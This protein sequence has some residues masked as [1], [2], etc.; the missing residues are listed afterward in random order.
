M[1]AAAGHPVRPASTSTPQPPPWHAIDASEVA[2]RLESD[3]HD[4]LSSAEADERAALHG[5]NALE[6]EPERGVV[7]LLVSQF[8]SPLIVIL[9]VAGVVTVA[10]GKYVDAAVITVVL[11]VNASIGFVQE[12]RADRSMHALM[13]LSSPTAVVVRDGR[14]TRVDASRLVSGDVVLLESGA[15]VPADLR[16]TATTSLRVDESLLTGESLPVDKDP[17]SVAEAAAAADRRSIAHAGTTVASGRGRGFVV[18][19][20]TSTELGRIAERIRS[21]ERPV[22]PLQARMARFANV[23]TMA[24]LATVVVSFALGLWRGADPADMFLVAVALAVAVIPEGLPIAFTVALALGVRRMADRNALVRSL[25]AVE[26]LGSTDVIGSDKTGTLTANRMTVVEAWTSD[27]SIGLAPGGEARPG[28]SGTLYDPSN[29]L[30][31]SLRSAVLANEADL[32]HVDGRVEHRGDPTETALLEVAER[33][34]LRVEALRSAARIVAVRPFEP[35][36]QYAAVV[37]DEEGPVLRVKGAPERIVAGCTTIATVSGQAAIDREAVLAAAARMAERGLRVLAAAER[38]LPAALAGESMPEPEGLLFTGLIGMQ[39][40][41]RAGVE[42]AIAACQRA[43]V[44]VLMITGDHVATARAIAQ[45]LGI[46]GAG[47]GGAMTGADLEALDADGLGRA[48]REVSVFARV[49]PDQKLAIVR[50][51]QAQGAVVAVTGDGINDA[52][53]LKA[54]D[55]GIA[56]GASGTDVAREASDMVLTDDAFVSIAAAVEEGRVVFENVRKVVS[57]LLATGVATI[58]SILGSLLAGW[59]LPYAP[60]AL[61][62]LNVVTN[63]LDDVALAFDP[64]EPDILDRPPRRRSEGIVS[65][66]LWRRAIVIGL[67]MGSGSL[68]LFR[69]A[70]GVGLTL[71]QQRGAALTTLVMAMSIHTFNARS[72]RR[73]LFT[74]DPRTNPLLLGA[75]VLPT[76]G[77]VFALGWAPTQSLLRIDAFP[78]AGW[79]R[80]ALVCAAVVIISDAHKLWRRRLERARPV[81][82]DVPG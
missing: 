47:D 65:A 11:L 8:T 45:D 67:A 14:A 34:G 44:R 71:E 3:P 39:D 9:L 63:G 72:E 57:F 59:P 38:R 50:S 1:T 46:D 4:G 2:E 32:V 31:A 68:W 76:L 27:G 17:A 77:H 37:V 13:A 23:V 82:A 74:I 75:V 70:H 36:L 61:L 18:A 33:V 81:G 16:L 24:V 73:L 26:T 58:L 79:G 41:P 78:A 51:L 69:W 40:P 62:W 35:A 10:L 80:I 15:R 53:A 20:G 7:D 6:P 66:M 55:I 43:G 28:T 60:A 25:P 52:P 42:E 22:T 64:G 19:I 48:V 30:A 54:A 49:A 56:M 21:T 29:A 5:A 12:R